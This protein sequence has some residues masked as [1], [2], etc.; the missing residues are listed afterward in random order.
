MSGAEDLA[1]VYRWGWLPLIGGCVLIAGVMIAGSEILLVRFGFGEAT[2]IERVLYVVRGAITSFALAVF[3]GWYMLRLRRRVE[4]AREALRVQQAALAKRAWQL[5]Q[6]VGLGAL[7]RLLVHELRDP[8]NGMSLHCRLL[9]RSVAALTPEHAASIGRIADSLKDDTCRL[10]GL[11]DDYLARNQAPGSAVRYEDVSLEAM[12]QDVVSARL[13]PGGVEIAVAAER[14]LAPVRAERERLRQLIEHLLGN[15]AD[16]PSGASKVRVTMANDG[17]HVLLTVAD[18]GS[19]FE[20]PGVV[21]RPFY[22]P[23]SLR[24]GLGLAI[25]RDVAREHGGETRAANVEHGGALVSVRLPI[26]HRAA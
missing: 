5:E 7:C 9:R 20:D 8:L 23:S 16:P 26:G 3:A 13:V 24:S 10:E 22:A 17:D 6:A 25:V 21:F 19:G 11:V 1:Q 4:E 18:D 2:T 12:V 15:A 14:D